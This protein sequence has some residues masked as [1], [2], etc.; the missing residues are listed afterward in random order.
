MGRQCLRDATT[1][2]TRIAR[3]VTQLTESLLHDVDDVL[4][5]PLPLVLGL[6]E[7]PVGLERHHLS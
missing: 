1:C 4:L 3:R 6:P 2:V 5:A 7:G